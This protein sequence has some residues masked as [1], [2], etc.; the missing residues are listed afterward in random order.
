MSSLSHQ[1]FVTFKTCQQLRI[2]HNLPPSFPS[3][4]IRDPNKVAIVTMYHVMCKKSLKC[5]TILCLGFHEKID[6]QL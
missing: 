4:S 2:E 6:F 1:T 3:H 5:K